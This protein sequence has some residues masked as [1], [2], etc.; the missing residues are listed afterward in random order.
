MPKETTDSPEKKSPLAHC[1][2][3]AAGAWATENAEA[4]SERQSWIRTHGT[5]LADLQVLR[6]EMDGGA[7]E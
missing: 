6:T 7:H 3:V 4:I 1:D 2:L 5:P